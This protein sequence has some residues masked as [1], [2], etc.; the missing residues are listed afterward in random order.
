MAWVLDGDLR[1]R[2]REF[3]QVL[4]CELNGQRTTV[5]VQAMQ[6]GRAGNRNDPPLLGEQPGERRQEQQPKQDLLVEPCTAE[7]HES[8]DQ[9]FRLD[10][11]GQRPPAALEP[12]DAHEEMPFEVVGVLA[13]T[14]TVLDRLVL[15]AVESVWHVHGTHGEKDADQEITAL[16]IRYATPGFFAFGLCSYPAGWL[17]DK[18]SRHGMMCVFFIGIGLASI[19]TGLARTPL[20]I[21]IGRAHV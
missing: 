10:C 14:G 9:A 4:R 1:R 3:T 7:R 20:Q 17:A 6:P 13:P 2:V 11:R 19:A 18:W 15:T 21:E 12:G 5:L 16:L 8:G